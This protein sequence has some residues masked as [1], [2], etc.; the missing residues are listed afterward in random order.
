RD[1][2]GRTQIG[3]RVGGPGRARTALPNRGGDRPSVRRTGAAAPTD[4]GDARL[5]ERTSQIRNV[6]GG[7]RVNEPP[8]DLG[9]TPGVRSRDHRPPGDMWSHR[10]DDAEHLRR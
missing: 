1:P 5:D 8:A 3:Y 9:R 6:V 2:R 4:D 10:S 7:R